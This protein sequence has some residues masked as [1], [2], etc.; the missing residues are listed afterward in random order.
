MKNNDEKLISITNCLEKFSDDE[1]VALN[2]LLHNE[3]VSIYKL[4]VA[5]RRAIKRK[6]DSRYGTRA[7]N[8]LNKKFD[9]KCMYDW[10]I[11]NSDEINILKINCINN[12][13]DLLRANLENLVGITPRLAIKLDEVRKFYNMKGYCEVD[14]AKKATGK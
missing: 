1:L 11:L 6:R 9:L 3:D 13:Y 7:Y 8:A 5:C 2:T 4:Q 12:L 14:V 10:G